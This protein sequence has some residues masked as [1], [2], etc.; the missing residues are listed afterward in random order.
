MNVI[1]RINK[2]SDK[3]YFYYDFGR[4]AGQRPATGIF[5]YAKPKDHIQRNHN[6]EAIQLLET[7][8]SQLTI[9]QQAVGNN[10]RSSLRINYQCQISGFPS[11]F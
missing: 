8:K 6:K 9:E 11:N 2:A 4:A 3:Y 1:K 10:A 5:I 7:K